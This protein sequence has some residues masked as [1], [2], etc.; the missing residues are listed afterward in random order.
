MLDFYTI[1]EVEGKK[2]QVVIKPSFLIIPHPSDLMIRGR[3]FYAYWDESTGL[4]SRDESGLFAMMDSE[5]YKHRKQVQADDTKKVVPVAKYIKRASSGVIDEWRRYC[6]KQMRDSYKEL[7]NKIIFRNTVTTKKD[8]ASKKLPY[9]LVSGEC[10]AWD[11][12]IGTLYSPEEREKIEWSIGAIISGDSKKIQKFVVFY[13]DGGTGK[14]TIMNIIEKLFEGYWN[15]FDAKELTSNNNTFSLESFKDNPLVSIQHDGDLSKI[16]DNTKLNS[17]VSHESMEVNE[18]FKSKY[19]MKF[20]TFLFM[21]TNKPVRITEAKSGIIRRLIDV[22]PTGHKIP[23]E[24][25]DTL[26]EQVDFELGQ[27]ASHCLKVYK[28]LGKSYYDNYIPKDMIASTNEFYNF[29]E[30]YYDMFLKENGV[31][32][33]KAYSLYKQYCTDVNVPYQLSYTKFRV[34]FATYFDE[35]KNRV[36]INGQEFFNYYLGFKWDKFP[37]HDGP[38][39]DVIDNESKEDGSY[40][41]KQDNDG[42]WI[43]FKDYSEFERGSFLNWSCGDCIAQYAKA[44]GTPKDYW[45]KVKTHLSDLD[46]RE[47]HYVLLPENHIVIDFDL[48][49]PDGEKNLQL[50]LEAAKKFPKTY[51]E[52]S[53]SGKGIHL[54]YIYDGDVSKL[55]HIYDEGIEIK[56]FGRKAALRRKLSLCNDLEISHINSGLPLKG[57]KNT[58]VDMNVVNLEKSLRTTIKK[59]LMKEVHGDTTSNVDFIKKIL[60]DAYASGKPYDVSDL[61][62]SIINFANNSSHQSSKCLKTVGQMKFKSAEQTRKAFDDGGF[63]ENNDVKQN[64]LSDIIFYDIEVFP[65]LFIVCWKT[66]HKDHVV[67]MINPTS[68]EVEPLLHQ[69][70]VGFNNRR[71]DNH[72][73]Y[74][75]AILGYTNMQ[76]YELSQKIINYNYRTD[77]Q[78]PTFTAAYNISY[79][80][81]WDFATNKQGLKQWEIELGI[82]HLENAHPWDEPVDE[83]YW[84]EIATYCANDVIATEAVFDHLDAD[85]KT[86]ELLSDLS[87][88]SL[89]DSNRNH[90]IKILIG[91]DKEA[92]HVYTD[93]ATGRQYLKGEKYEWKSGKT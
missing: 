27:I 50:N 91:N 59:C 39:N 8:Y 42:N 34:E 57:V 71:Y 44:D 36:K 66:Y 30:E 11:E 68:L 77:P 86:R 33:K 81:V 61:M 32:A 79:T 47:L 15:R 84:E 48:K 60:D 43:I 90:I 53:K 82:Y 26:V 87:G 40:E 25:Y 10:P 73:L 74:A 76:L 2:G 52:T 22:R 18:K 62:Q 51:A 5:V 88:L 24:R 92:D 67:K 6:Q 17:I 38:A 19:V 93:L 69:K 55:S 31:S 49:G 46:W 16:E 14:S 65:N 54:H 23:R 64:D 56:T 45:S 78:P 29:V 21:G 9:D 63:I 4:W 58:V 70:L 1:D 75:R 89:N 35:V 13:G 85:F 41:I 80:D 72:I 83:K 12:I 7:D 28:K 37:G 3:D 20:N